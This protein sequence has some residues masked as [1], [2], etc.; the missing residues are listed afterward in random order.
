MITRSLVLTT[1][2]L[3][4]DLFYYLAPSCFAESL[5]DYVSTSRHLNDW[6]I[7]KSASCRQ[8]SILK[9]GLCNQ[10]HYRLP[11]QAR[12]LEGIHD[13]KADGLNNSSW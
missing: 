2:S 5:M 12:S 9:M 4:L 10:A 3:R 6:A 13:R 7:V 1:L 8:L 11:T